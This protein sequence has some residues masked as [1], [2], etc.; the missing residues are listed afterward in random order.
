[1]LGRPELGVTL[2][3]LHVWTLTQY[4]KVVFV[5]ADTM[6]SEHQII[7]CSFFLL[8]FPFLSFLSLLLQSRLTYFFFFHYL[9][10]QILQNIDVLFEGTADFAAA[11]DVGWPD[12]FNSGVFVCKP[13]METFRRLLD[14]T[15]E[16]GSFDGLPFPSS[17]SF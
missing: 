5:D 15:A 2:T 17:C 13:S 1:L 3:K 12:C 7:T 16:I 9:F 10:L 14:K 4:E 11:P 6:V 8:P